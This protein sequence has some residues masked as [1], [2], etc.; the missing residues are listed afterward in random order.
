MC[1][2]VGNSQRPISLLLY[3]KRLKPTIEENIDTKSSVWVLKPTYDDPVSLSISNSNR[4]YTE[5]NRLII[6]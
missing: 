6:S 4:Q 1:L 5:E 3:L 2:E